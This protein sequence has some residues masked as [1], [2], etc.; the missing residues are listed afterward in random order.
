MEAPITNFAVSNGLVNLPLYNA[1]GFCGLCLYKDT[2]GS[3][4]NHSCISGNPIVVDSSSK[5]QPR[6]SSSGSETSDNPPNLVSTT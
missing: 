4:T 5:N 3:V 1:T 6:Y 2:Y